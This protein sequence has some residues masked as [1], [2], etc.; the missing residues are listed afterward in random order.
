M[1]AR[2]SDPATSHAAA[3]AITYAAPGIEQDILDY[4]EAYG[5]S[6]IQEIADG[7]AINL[8]TVSPRVAPLRRRGQVHSIGKRKNPSGCLALVWALGPEPDAAPAAVPLPEP[9][10]VRVLGMTETEWKAN[11]TA[12]LTACGDLLEVVRR[13]SIR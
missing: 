8:V 9:E 12:Y 13:L 1:H 7:T 4:I 10:P 3:T 11:R 6:T 5:P 2:K